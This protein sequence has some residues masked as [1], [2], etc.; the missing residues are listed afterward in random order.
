VLLNLLPFF[1][2]LGLTRIF[3]SIVTGGC[4][5]I[6][7][8]N[9]FKSIAEVINHAGVTWTSLVPSQVRLMNKMSGKLHSGFR[10]ATTSAGPCDTKDFQQFFETFGR[11]LLSEYGCTE[12]GIISSNTL[13]DNRV[14]SVGLPRP[15]SV[16]I[17]QG[18]ICYRPPWQDRAEFM[19]TGDLGCLDSDG[20]LW[21]KGRIKEMIKRNGVPLIP[22]EIENYI[23][24]LP[25]ID[26]CAVYIDGIDRKGDVMGLVFTGSVTDT[27][28]RNLLWRANPDLA[29]G[30]QRITPVSEIPLVNNKIRRL[31]IKNYVDQL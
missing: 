19:G 5:V 21:I 17:R 2:G 27:E 8:S 9:V 28:L 26:Q 31:E 15:G 1:H 10:F 4:Q 12:A 22:Q 16:D 24:T 6:P 25:G 7:H 3:T 30:I 18:E 14:G 29:R 11:P 20:F 23:K 13:A